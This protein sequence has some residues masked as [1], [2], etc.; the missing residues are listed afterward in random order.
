M[1]KQF[2]KYLLAT[3][4]LIGAV[5]TSHAQTKV[6]VKVRPAEVVTTRPVAPRAD[7][8]WIGDEW[9]VKKGAY[10]HVAGYWAEPHPG[11]IWKPGH[12]SSEAKGD[13]WIAGHWKKV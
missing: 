11:Y 1:K 8:I 4:L 10:V 9:T 5:T 7:Y 13:Y 12:W 3:F 6:Y 2:L